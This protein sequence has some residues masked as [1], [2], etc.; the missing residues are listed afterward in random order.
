M[1]LYLIVIE[2]D[3]HLFLNFRTIAT[4][5]KIS[6]LLPAVSHVSRPFIRMALISTFNPAVL[7]D[8][9]IYLIRVCV[10]ECFGRLV[11]KV[12]NESPINVVSLHV[13]RSADRRPDTG[14]MLGNL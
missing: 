2:F 3:N 14:A 9:D 13:G 8:W 5:R 4:M 7:R 1:R 11:M 6:T 12:V 10:K